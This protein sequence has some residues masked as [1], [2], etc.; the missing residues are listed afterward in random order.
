MST[1]SGGKLQKLLII[2]AWLHLAAI[3]L[4]GSL[5]YIVP[6]DTWYA[7]VILYAPRWI[8]ALP[9]IVLLPLG[10]VKIRKLLLPEGLSLLLVVWPI[11]GLC[12]PWR[13][14][15]GDTPQWRIV[16]CNV[17][18]AAVDAEQLR[19]LLRNLEADVIVLQECSA[20]LAEMVAADGDWHKHQA[21]QLVLLS[22]W[23]I[24]EAEVYRSQF[25]SWGAY[26]AVR[27]QLDAQ[28]GPISF[29]N[30]HLETPRDGFEALIHAEPGAIEQIRAQTDRQSKEAQA[31]A[32]I[33]RHS[34]EPSLLAGDFNLPVE[35]SLYRN[36]FGGYRNAFS[37][38]GWG[39]GS[40]KFTRWHGIRIDHVLAS[41]EW[42]IQRCWVGADVGSDH[43]PVIAE[44]SLSAP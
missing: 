14:P 10:L 31:V 28:P 3:G 40:T 13:A 25:S 6:N 18:G 26:R 2:G 19:A 15:A 23:P 20:E 44:V 16:T 32:D 36:A 34:N 7:M 1:G 37:C 24:A 11:M 22:R 12:I 5:F 27:Y 17:G 30:L 9:C 42:N 35:S 39:W 4:V 43:R 21:H 33:A 29:V 41:D 8:W 38:A